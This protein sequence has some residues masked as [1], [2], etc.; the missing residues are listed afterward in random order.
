MQ[1]IDVRLRRNLRERDIE[2]KAEKSSCSQPTSRW[3]R[4]QLRTCLSTSASSAPD[5]VPL[6]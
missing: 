5:S 4:S 3:Q 1:K 2:R 6:T